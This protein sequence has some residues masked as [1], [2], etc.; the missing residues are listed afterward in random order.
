[1]VTAMMR[2]ATPIL[3]MAVVTVPERYVTTAVTS[4]SIYSNSIPGRRAGFSR[5]QCKR[6]DVRDEVDDDRKTTRQSDDVGQSVPEHF[7]F[8]GGHGLGRFS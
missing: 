4:I 2:T 6:L 8:G 5:L 7:K 1:M 3:V